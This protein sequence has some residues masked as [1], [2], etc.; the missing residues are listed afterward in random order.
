MNKV[1]SEY[2]RVLLDRY[3]DGE[4]SQEELKLLK[5]YFCYTQDLPKDLIPYAQMFTIL[6]ERQQ[7]PSVEALDRFSEVQATT[8]SRRIPLWPFIAAACIAAFAV[9]L[10]APPQQKEES[11]AVAYVDGKMLNDKTLAMQIGQ[12]ALQEIFS[13]GNEEQQLHELFNTP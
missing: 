1:T 5:D 3:M 10:L 13:N 7:T 12:E 2:V 8:T 6:D 9:I 4:S 11:M